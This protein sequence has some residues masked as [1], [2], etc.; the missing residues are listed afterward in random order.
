M[1]WQ[2]LVQPRVVDD[3]AG[4]CL[5]FTQSVWGAPVKYASAWDSW[6]ATPNKQLNRDIPDGV[7]VLVWF[8]HWGRYGQNNEYKNW[9]HVVTHMP[10]NRYLSSPASGYGH[11]WF[12]TIEQ[13]E[14]TFNA[15]YVGWS[16]S[17]NGLT[18][19]QQSAPPPPPPPVL[20]NNKMYILSVEGRA[21][22]VGK[23]YC[24]KIHDHYVY[25]RMIPLYGQAY[26]LIDSDDWNRL[27]WTLG[28]PAEVR[29][30]L[31]AN[32][33]LWACWD[34]ERGYFIGSDGK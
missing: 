1:S 29:G 24:A 32:P 28:I 15:K 19:A 20:D 14:R 7:G 33:S 12:D 18:V 31:I 10:N 27:T 4:W 17:I 26:Q 2:Q 8:E 22:L 16:T 11:Q 34:A 21:W 5:R 13:V 3:G 23:G 6:L 9:G 30:K 25:T